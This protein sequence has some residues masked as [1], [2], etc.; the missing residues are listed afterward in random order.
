MPRNDDFEGAARELRDS[1]LVGVAGSAAGVI[2]R[3]ARHSRIAAKAD[4]LV[5]DFR[6]WPAVTRVR[7]ITLTIAVAAGAHVMLE[8]LVPPH[9]APS[10][11]PWLWVA[12]GIVS[13][14]VAAAAGSARRSG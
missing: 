4:G 1:W 9:F 14:A 6:S 13:A 7:L 8:M 10:I 5:R 11:S 12:V 3:G 2:A